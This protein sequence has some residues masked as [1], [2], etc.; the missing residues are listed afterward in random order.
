MVKRIKL[1]QRKYAI[2]DDEDYEYLMQWKWSAHKRS[3][4]FYAIRS[5]TVDLNKQYS[6]YMHRLI[7]NAQKGELVD[8]I[9]HD[10]LDNR[11][12]NLRICTHKENCRN[13]IVPSNNT[14]GYKGV[15]WNKRLNKWRC[16]IKL[17]NSRILLGYFDTII[18]AAYAYDEAAIY[19]FGEFAYLNFPDLT[20]EDRNC[21]TKTHLRIKNDRS[22]CMLSNNSSGY[23]GVCLDKKSNKWK[24][25]IYANGRRVHLG[26]FDNKIEAAIV[27]DQNAIIYHASKACL[28]FPMYV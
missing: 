26:Y 21:S 3:K 15:S 8:H 14:S 10:T 19:N 6:N 7:M 2:V 18:E 20:S 24:C 1:T 13:K 23:R 11:R 4:L 25:S 17:D 16:D 27:Y 22:Y 12:C 28:N 5:E 9:N